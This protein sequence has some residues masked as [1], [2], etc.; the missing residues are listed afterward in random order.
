MNQNS[1]ATSLQIIPCGFKDAKILS[2]IAIRSYT[3]FYL[4]LWYDNGEW[5]INH[6]FAP[7]IL[8]KELKDL[9]HAFFLLKENENPVGFLKLNID[10]PLKGYNQYN[11]IELE[12]IY[13][14]RSVTGKGYGRLA[15]EFCFDYSRKLKKEIIWLKTMDSS[16]TVFFYKKLEFEPCGNFYLDF[17]QMKPEFRGMIIFMKEL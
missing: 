7:A 17:P 8:E 4:S 1:A 3:E 6:S 14:I 9:N 16:D 12:R 15:M 13:F 5:Y 10:Q 2:E 11:C